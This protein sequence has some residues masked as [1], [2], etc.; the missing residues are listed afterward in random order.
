MIKELTDQNFEAETAKGV[1]FT[2]FW[3]HGAVLAGCKAPLLIN[4]L[5]K[6]ATR[7]NLEKW[8]LIKILGQPKNWELC[9]FQQWLSKKMVKL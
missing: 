5:M 9:Q 2:D 3:E 7:F 4:W 1:T 8:I 6:W